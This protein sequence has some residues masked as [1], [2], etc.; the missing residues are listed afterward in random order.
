M[1]YNQI[2][3]PRSSYYYERKVPSENGGEHVVVRRG[4]ETD[5]LMLPLPEVDDVY[6]KISITPNLSLLLFPNLNS[7]RCF[8]HF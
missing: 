7:C 8:R 6:L 4:D 5:I 3:L 2:I 1:L